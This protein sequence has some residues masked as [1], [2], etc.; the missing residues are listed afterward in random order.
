M[1][2]K[3]DVCNA[4]INNIEDKILD[5]ANLAT[6][7]TKM[8]EVKGEIPGITNLSTTAVLIAV[9]TKKPSISKLVKKKHMQKLM[10]LKRK[11]LTMIIINTGWAKKTHSNFKSLYFTNRD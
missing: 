9:E 11:L 2:A 5:I 4:K 7:T 1:F 10:K 3:K 8:N 6:K